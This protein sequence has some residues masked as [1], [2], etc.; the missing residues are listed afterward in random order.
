MEVPAEVKWPWGCPM[1]VWQWVIKASLLFLCNPQSQLQ[2]EAHRQPCWFCC[3]ETLP[4]SGR[5]CSEGMPPSYLWHEAHTSSENAETHFLLD[6]WEKDEL[7][8]SFL[9]VSEN[10]RVCFCS[11]LVLT[12]RVAG[13]ILDKWMLWKKVVG[14]RASAAGSAAWLVE[15]IPGFSPCHCMNR[16]TCL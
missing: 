10:R 7:K 8:Y 3:S 16:H 12:A 14:S 6:S 15:C 4:N 11:A 13:N 2:A 1:E 9:L 5:E